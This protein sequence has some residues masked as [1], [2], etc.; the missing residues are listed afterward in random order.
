MM[1]QVVRTT[2]FSSLSRVA[3]NWTRCNI[4][5]ICDRY[6]RFDILTLG[7][8]L[9]KN[10]TLIKSVFSLPDVSLFC[11]H[12]KDYSPLVT[13]ILFFFLKKIFQSAI[14]GQP[15]VYVKYLNIISYANGANHN[16][17]GCQSLCGHPWSRMK[18]KR[19]ERGLH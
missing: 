12:K 14:H 9:Y 2:C 7:V 15:R 17:D 3:Y 6:A 19:C 13:S 5:I 18:T 4:I 16:S 1:R 8:N 11:S 10:H